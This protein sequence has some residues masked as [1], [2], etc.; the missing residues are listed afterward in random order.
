[1]PAGLGAADPKA[2]AELTDSERELVRSLLLALCDMQEDE[3]AAALTSL[4]EDIVRLLGV[5]GPVTNRYIPHSPAGNFKQW[6][7]LSQVVNEIRE[8]FYGG[9]A[10]GGKSDGLLIGALQYVDV[11]G[12]AAIILRRTYQDLSLPGA[13]MDRARS[14]LLGTDAVWNDKLKRWTFPSSA[15]LVF[16]YLEH[17]GDEERYQSAEFQY[18]GWDE[19]SQIPQ[20]Q[21]DYVNARCRRPGPH[22]PGARDLAAVPLRIRI[23]SNPGGIG[24]AYLKERYIEPARA[25]RL[26]VGTAV[27]RASLADN[28]YIDRVSYE[29]MLNAIAD[30]TDRQRLRDGDWDVMPAGGLL[31]RSWV[32]Y[33]D[34]APAELAPFTLSRGGARLVRS[35]D[36]AG[37]DKSKKDRDPDWT[38]GV[39][40][41]KLDGRVY[42]LDVRYVRASPGKVEA[43]IQATAAE[44]GK[45]VPIRL[46]QEPGQSGKAQIVRY[47]TLLLGHTV[48][49]STSTGSKVLRAGAVASAAEAGNLYVVTDYYQTGERQPWVNWAVDQLVQ[50]P[51]GHDDVMDAV[52]AGLDYLTPMPKGARQRPVGLSV[53]SV[54][55]ASQKV[56]RLPAVT[57]ASKLDYER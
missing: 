24:H 3:R 46:E 56:D 11:P 8:V 54:A 5:C 31:D 45:Q 1:M 17:E 40:L 39:L 48:A 33:L 19:G 47:R 30:P 51:S 26:P 15:V 43:L 37:T 27:I 14:W 34:S 23:G 41:G 12:Y 4:D 35:W 25:K 38:V 29:L 10:G 55:A 57:E 42:L 32:R 6:V 7:L 13:L 28:P 52:S 50:F 22:K 36:L 16:G 53:P 20:R 21:I 44:D 49:A 9:A 2:Y 18:I